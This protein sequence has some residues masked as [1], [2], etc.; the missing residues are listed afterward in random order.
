MKRHS[1]EFTRAF[2]LKR[3]GSAAASLEN[4]PVADRS[5]SILGIYAKSSFGEKMSHL[6]GLSMFVTDCLRGPAGSGGR[7]PILSNH[8]A[9]TGCR[10]QGLSRI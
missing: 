10:S 3:V 9:Q 6:P 1:E 4:F 8:G 2:F 5:S 7:V